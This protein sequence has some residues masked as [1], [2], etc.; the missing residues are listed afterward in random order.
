MSTKKLSAPDWNSGY[1]RSGGKGWTADMVRQYPSPNGDKQ[2]VHI[3][4]MTYVGVAPG[5]VHWHVAIA[6]RK[7]PVWDGECWASFGDDPEEKPRDEFTSFVKRDRAIRWA[8]RMLNEKFPAEHWEHRWEEAD[9]NELSEDPAE[10]AAVQSCACCQA[11]VGEHTEEERDECA[12]ILRSVRNV[13]PITPTGALRPLIGTS[14]C[15]VLVD[16]GN[17]AI[18]GK[19]GSNIIVLADMNPSYVGLLPG[20]KALIVERGG[21]LVHLAQ[22]ARELGVAVVLQSDATSRF[23]DG[24]TLTVH[25]DTCEIEEH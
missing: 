5:A 1:S 22:V 13:P 3:S 12:K 19:V 15:R 14:D 20:A 23:S 10:E 16:P 24:M 6:P 2:E 21:A 7:N 4:F 18:T 11:P 8:R 17:G 9:P 25:F